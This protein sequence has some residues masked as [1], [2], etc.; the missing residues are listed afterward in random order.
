MPAASRSDR[1]LLHGDGPSELL[2]TDTYPTDGE[3][4]ERRHVPTPSWLSLSPSERMRLRA[5]PSANLLL[6][7]IVVGFVVLVAVSMVVA[8]FGTVRLGFRVSMGIIGFTMAGVAIGFLVIRGREYVLTTERACR[9]V[10][11]TTKQVTTID[12]DRVADIALEQ[13]AWQRWMGVG[14]LEFVTHDGESLRFELV[15]E[16][17]FVYENALDLL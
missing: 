15:E 2:G 14:T 10:G 8:Q 16:P 13:P 11:P 7:I 17:Q 3:M 4:S 1:P 9:A 6:V 12:L 5:S